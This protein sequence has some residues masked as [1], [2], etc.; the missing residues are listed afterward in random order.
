M[1]ERPIRPEATAADAALA[2]KLMAEADA[3]TLAVIDDVGLPYAAL[4]A[5][6]VAADGTPLVLTSALAAH[7]RA[8]A[9]DGRASLLIAAAIDPSQPLAG[10]R[11]TIQGTAAP[12][13]AGDRERYLA[14]RPDAELYIDF[15]DMILRRI[16]PERLVLIVGFGRAVGL[17]PAMLAEA[18]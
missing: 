10:S 15:G 9:A 13:V 16:A 18:L 11:L 4:T 3:A 2:R 1:N 14:R 8:L 17:P 6:A 7:G 5:H 12:A